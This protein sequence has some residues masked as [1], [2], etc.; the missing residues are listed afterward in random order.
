[1][2][3]KKGKGWFAILLGKKVDPQTTIPQYILDAIAFA[4]PSLKKEVLIKII[5]YRL[6]YIENSNLFTTS[7]LNKFRINLQNFQNGNIDFHKG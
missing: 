1:M 6:T 7:E 5:N 4:Q 3:E 2:A